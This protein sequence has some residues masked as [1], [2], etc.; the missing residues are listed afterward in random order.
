MRPPVLE[1]VPVLPAP[2]EALLAAARRG[3]KSPADHAR[4][5]REIPAFHLVEHREP[6]RPAPVPGRFTVAAFN[7]ERLKFPAPTRALVE[8]AGAQAVL[9][10][11]ADVGMAR[12]GNRHTLEE[13]ARGTGAGHVYGVEFV[14]LDLGD[15]KEM[16]AHAGERNLRSFHGNGIVTGFTL[17]DPCVIPLEEG[18]FWFPGRG[19]AQRRIGGRIAVAARMAE[20]PA[21]LWLVS[22]HLESKTDARDRLAQVEAL[23]R[24]LDAVAPGAAV[25]IG[26]DFNT[27]ALPVRA[28]EILRR[29]QASEPL[30]EALAAAGFTW[31]ASNLP[32][33]TQRK[34]PSGKGDPP[35]RK[36]DWIVT[37]GVSVERPRVLAAVDGEGRP[38]SDHEMVAVDVIV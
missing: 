3:A 5:M 2:E 33:P 17:A 27:K 9:V 1:R 20:A 7:A 18:G 24:G 28:Q 35:F 15:R 11:E 23:L 37:R 12:S 29:P 14:E 30:F 32:L 36:L 13:I 8:R 26:G 4:L 19:G 38:I 21:P 6:A 22:V 31:E 25:V 34:G 16:E 10:C